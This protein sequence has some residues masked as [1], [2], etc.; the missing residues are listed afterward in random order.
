M[1]TGVKIRV[2]L[3]CIFDARNRYR[4][5]ASAAMTLIRPVVLAGG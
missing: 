2:P 4:S 5:A 3:T 1:P